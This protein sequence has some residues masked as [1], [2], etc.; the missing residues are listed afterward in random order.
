MDALGIKNAIHNTSARNTGKK[1]GTTWRHLECLKIVTL[2]F[3]N[4]NIEVF[5]DKVT[6]IL[7]FITITWLLKISTDFTG[8]AF[9][10]R[11][12]NIGSS[13]CGFSKSRVVV[14]ILKD[15]YRRQVICKQWI[16]LSGAAK[17]IRITGILIMTT[18]HT[19]PQERQL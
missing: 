4:S 12:Q 11:N 3:K 13:Y 18:K 16:V 8:D 7:K 2:M 14:W 17:I 9:K 19:Y 15:P 10:K 6:L 1:E 5:A